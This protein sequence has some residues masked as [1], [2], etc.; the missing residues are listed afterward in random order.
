MTTGQ[1]IKEARKRVGMTQKELAQKLGIPFQGISQWENDLRNPKLETLQKIA[2]AIGVPISDLVGL[3]IDAKT[4]ESILCDSKHA[5]TFET[6]E[7]IGVKSR[8]GFVRFRKDYLLYKENSAR[9]KAAF[10]NLNETGQQKAVERVE[11]LAKIPDYQKTKPENNP[12]D[13][14]ILAAKGGGLTKKELTPEQV[15]KLKKW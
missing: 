12:N 9:L 7:H 13:E 3:P 14:I 4:M 10:D 8:S 11:E 6:D 5:T 15:D 2:D 1:K